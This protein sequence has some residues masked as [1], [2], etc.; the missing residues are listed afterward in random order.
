MADG[1]AFFIGNQTAFSVPLAEPFDFAVE[2]HF[3]AFEFFPDGGPRGRGWSAVDVSADERRRFRAT[4]AERGMRLS[5]HAALAAQL[6]DEGSWPGLM[7]DVELARDL[8][9]RVINLHL[10]S[11]NPEG[12]AAAALALVE[13]LQPLGITLALENTVRVAPDDV[14]QIFRL[15]QD[16]LGKPHGSVGLCLD[17]GHANLC[18]A[19]RNDYLRFVDGLGDHV[20]IVHAHIHENWGDADTHLTLFT[21]PAG[22]DPSGVEGLLQRLR[23]RG[24]RGS[25][26]LE[27]WPTPS[28]LLL[29]AR[30]RLRSIR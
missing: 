19:T 5:V 23:R 25:L 29:S 13:I 22:R 8:G 3:D 27:Q 6:L 15:M 18:S 1:Y 16:D 10:G 11:G 20:P 14:N 24:F 7:R 26:I 21:G 4:A 2:H 17:I 28:S 9:A 30:D 12:C